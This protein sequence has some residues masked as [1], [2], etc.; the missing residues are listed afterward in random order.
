MREFGN[1]LMLHNDVASREQRGWTPIE[2]VQRQF[3]FVVKL[4]DCIGGST[5]F[6]PRMWCPE[7]EAY[8]NAADNYSYDMKVVADVAEFELK[9]PKGSL[10]VFD[11]RNYHRVTKVLFGR[12]YTAG[13]FIEELPDGTLVVWS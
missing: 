10:L 12:R 7:D 2:K 13:G 1:E 4:T 6:Y 9:G 5:C 11:C 8:F 3:A